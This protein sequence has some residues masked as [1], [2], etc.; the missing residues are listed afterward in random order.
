MRLKKR[1]KIILLPLIFLLAMTS[2]VWAETDN[3]VIS[4]NLTVPNYVSLRNEDKL[5]TPLGH[6][7]SV[8]RFD[9]DTGQQEW[10]TYGII[11]SKENLSAP[12][13]KIY[14]T[15][16]GGSTIV[17]LRG[18]GVAN[19]S[20]TV[21]HLWDEICVYDP[22]LYYC[23]SIYGYGWNY[24][25]E[26]NTV[27][28]FHVFIGCDA[29]QIKSRRESLKTA[30]E[31][32]LKDID[33]SWDD[34]E[35][36]L[37]IHDYLGQSI[38]YDFTPNDQTPYGALVEKRCVCN[39][40]ATS[41]EMLMDFLGIQTIRVV[42]EPM[43]HA[44]NMIKL[45]GDWYHVDNTW[46]DVNI[47]DLADPYV[48]YNY[49]LRTD[50]EMQRDDLRHYDWNS[51]EITARSK[52]FENL[53][54]KGCEAYVFSEDAWFYSGKEGLMKATYN[55]TN[56][57]VAKPDLHPGGLLA[58]GKQLYLTQYHSIYRWTPENGRMVE[59]Y[60]LSTTDQGNYGQMYRLFKL[61]KGSLGYTFW[62]DDTGNECEGS[63][64]I[65]I[66]PH[67]GD[68]NADAVIDIMDM[69]LIQDHI[70]GKQPLAKEEYTVADINGD[71]IVDIMDMLAIQD[72]I[73]G[74]VKIDQR[75]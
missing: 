46:D 51:Q 30:T 70:L 36:A 56:P 37:A 53:P 35:K 25:T 29:A 41:Y 1:W 8:E 72:D 14:D 66:A 11:D 75:D 40:Y 44:W 5:Y 13:K 28:D 2:L 4:E 6:M 12:S 62:D 20:T 50:D 19:D 73:L 67:K 68:V 47:N 33:P 61:Q 16:L 39:G 34:K 74:K 48:S 45:D 60:T 57:K 42:S 38:T 71:G 55:G 69:L 31:I 22:L 10:S 58:L 7:D 32:V 63:C 26:N 43:N 15:L 17:D 9:R 24:T 3:M 59:V 52:A 65:V 21:A 23:I 49:F 27:T 18:L 64:T 54:R